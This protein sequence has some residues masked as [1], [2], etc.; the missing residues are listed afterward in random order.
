VQ[1]A[2]LVRYIP[3]KLIRT[4]QLSESAI[5]SE[6]NS[7]DLRWPSVRADICT[8][9]HGRVNAQLFAELNPTVSYDVFAWRVARAILCRTDSKQ[10]VPGLKEHELICITKEKHNDVVGLEP[11]SAKSKLIDSRVASGTARE[12]LLP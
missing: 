4:K 5:E 3:I 9:M 8:E 11:A 12:V 6:F 10:I 2:C 7:S 1:F